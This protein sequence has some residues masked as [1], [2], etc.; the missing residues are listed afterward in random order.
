[1]YSTAALGTAAA[2]GAVAASRLPFTGFPTALMVVLALV[3]VLCGVAMLR[4][5]TVLRRSGSEA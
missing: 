5:A 2:G 3:A 1:M 4:T